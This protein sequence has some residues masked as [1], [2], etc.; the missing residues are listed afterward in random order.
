MHFFAEIIRIGALTVRAKPSSL[1]ADFHGLEL[2]GRLHEVQPLVGHVAP[3]GPVFV[4]HDAAE[5]AEEEIEGMK[6]SSTIEV[7]I[8]KENPFPKARNFSTIITRC[9]F[10]NDEGFL[11][12]VG[13]K[14]MTYDK[15]INYLKS[16]IAKL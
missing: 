5:I 4:A 3:L 1:F 7:F 15:N 6:L 13:P 10:P 8:G 16:L 9:H 2:A 12:I 14:R 11:A